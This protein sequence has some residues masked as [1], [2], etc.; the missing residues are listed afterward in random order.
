MRTVDKVL[1]VKTGR[2]KFA[3]IILLATF[4]IPISIG[5]FFDNLQIKNY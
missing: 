5:V 4:A 1:Y 3:K 2:K